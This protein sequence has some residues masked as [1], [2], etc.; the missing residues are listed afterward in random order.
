MSEL[1]AHVALSSVLTASVDVRSRPALLA[2]VAPRIPAPR[3]APDDVAPAP[4]PRG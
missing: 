1:P 4:A 3:T 2:A